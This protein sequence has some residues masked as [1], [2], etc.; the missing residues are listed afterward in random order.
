MYS[1]AVSNPK[2]LQDIENNI[3]SL[4]RRQDELE[5]QQ[6]EFMVSVEDAQSALAQA[7][8]T[9]ETAIQQ[10]AASNQDLL[11]EKEALESE[12]T[13]LNQER[14]QVTSQIDA[15]YLTLYQEMLPKMAYRPVAQLTDERM[16]S[17]CGV[18]QTS[19]HSQAIKQSNEIM[20][21][22]NCNRLLIA[23]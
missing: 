8:S 12:L 21:C 5:D 2:E 4:K 14:L 17:I 13:S 23:T 20:H 11:S 7:Q 3:A 15:H 1:G 18:Q 16:C 19:L 22:A 9:L 10:A 6:L